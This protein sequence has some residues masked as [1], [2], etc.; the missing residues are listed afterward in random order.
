MIQTGKLLEGHHPPHLF[1]ENT[2]Y[3]VTA[4][5]VAGEFLLYS[6]E[7]KILV[8]DTLKQ[9]IINGQIKLQA[10]VILNNHYHLLLK[11]PHGDRLPRLIGQLHGSTSRQLNLWENVTGRQV[12]HN[13]WDTCM[14]TERDFWT[15]FNY[16]HNNPVKHGYVKRPADWEFSSY[17][18]YLRTHGKE[19]LQDVFMSYPVIDYSD[20][21]DDF[22]L[23][24]AG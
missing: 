11:P 9:L 18:Y 8:R 12:W 13:Y 24:S 14:R 1:L 20:G 21:R 19:W 22:D 10:W 23:A 16:I 15:R 7:A 4:N 6:R 5:T 3:A 2:W 17:Q